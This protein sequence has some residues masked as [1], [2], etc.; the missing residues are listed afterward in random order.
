ME[1]LLIAFLRL[2]FLGTNI[3]STEKKLIKEEA[4]IQSLYMSLTL[5]GVPIPFRDTTTLGELKLKEDPPKTRKLLP[6]KAVAESFSN[7]ACNYVYVIV[8][9]PG[10]IPLS[11]SLPPLSILLAF[12]SIQRR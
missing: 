1:G 12:V 11:K 2:K 10:M 9:V 3:S 5:W 4:E 7:P 6:L 8:D